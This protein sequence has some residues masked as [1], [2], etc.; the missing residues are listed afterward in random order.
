MQD[1]I[2]KYLAHIEHNRNFSPQ[3]L[4]AYRNDLHQYFSFLTAEGCGNLGN[5]TRLI[6]RKFLAFLKKN[7]DYSKTTIARKLV[8]IRSLYKFLCHEGILELNPVENVRSPKL[9]RN[10]PGFMSINETETLLN[11]PNLSALLGARDSAIMETLYSTGMRVSELA[12]INVTDVD[13][14]KGLVKVKGKGKK[15]RLLP[16][17]NHALHAI[18]LYMGKRGSDKPALFLNNRGGRLTERSVARMLEKYVKR[19]G[20]NLNVSP[21]T[22]R[23]S[24]ATHLLDRGADLRSVQEL[25]GHANLSTTQIYTHITTERLRRVYDKAHPRA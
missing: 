23:H 7:Q 20:I 18:Q 13:F 17:G 10:L 21:H 12:G 19:A 1:H 2:N 6:L 16:I 25:L 11:T 22:F 3:T 9:D 14:D 8:S 24:F 5:V 15:E 4:R